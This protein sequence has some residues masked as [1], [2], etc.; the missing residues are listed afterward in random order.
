MN[1][2]NAMYYKIAFGMIGLL[3]I[4]AITLWTNARDIAR[5]AWVESYE[6]CV[7]IS[8]GMTPTAY[9]QI[10]GKYPNCNAD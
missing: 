1:H 9:Y 8:Y 2:R 3:V 5:S 10:H 6:E 4:I 7:Y